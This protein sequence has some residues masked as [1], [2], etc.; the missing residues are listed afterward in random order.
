[1]RGAGVGIRERRGKVLTTEGAEAGGEHPPPFDFAQGRL[2]R[3]VRE[4]WGTWVFW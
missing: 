3:K 2:S 1:M 4:K